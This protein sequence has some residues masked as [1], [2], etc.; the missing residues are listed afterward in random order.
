MKIAADSHQK[1][2]EFFRLYFKDE[3]L[4]LPEFKI[5]CGFWARKICRIFKIHGVTLGQ[6]V[7]IDPVFVTIDYAGKIQAPFELIVHEATHVLQYARE[8]FFGFLTGYLKEWLAFLREQKKRD[9]Q[10][11]WRAY[12]AISHETEA[13]Q[14][15]S[16]YSEWKTELAQRKKES[17]RIEQI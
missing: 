9:L 11:R 6:H 13:R 10:T 14:A 17:P 16:A 1:I 12:Y 8:G 15:A 3:K 7:F 2:E 5:Y 4:V